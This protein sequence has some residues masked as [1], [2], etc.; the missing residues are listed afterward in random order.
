MSFADEIAA[1]T[2]WM[3]ARGEGEAGMR[4][5]AA[6]LVNRLRSGKWGKTLASVCLAPF[7]FSCWN[8]SDPNRRAMADLDENDPLLLSALA[9][10]ADAESGNVPDPTNGA[11]HYYATGT[12]DPA[13]VKVARFEGK[14]GHHFFFS[15]V[16]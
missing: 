3:E 13:W 16:P 11:T 14:I 8:T 12:P 9:Y 7:Q 10:V 15:H 1:R 2:C 5:V 6:V 4:A